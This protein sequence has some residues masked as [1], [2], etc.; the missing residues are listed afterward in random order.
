MFS[1]R[2]FVRM[3]IP[4]S[5]LQVQR[6]LLRPQLVSIFPYSKVLK[7]SY[8]IYLHSLESKHLSPMN[9]IHLHTLFSGLE[10][11]GKY[12]VCNIVE[13]RNDWIRVGG[14]RLLREM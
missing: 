1:A 10:L 4:M 6:L 12:S 14:Y 2:L 5:G 7:D 13:C 8:E 11:L 3:E 9:R